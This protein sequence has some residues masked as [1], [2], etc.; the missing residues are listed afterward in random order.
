M[1][2]Y[3][4]EGQD[5]L[6]S[7]VVAVDAQ[8]LTDFFAKIAGNGNKYIVVSTHSDFGICEQKEF[9]AWK[10]I[11]KWCGMCAEPSIGYSDFNIHARLNKEKCNIEDKYS[12]KCWAWTS[13]TFNEIPSNVV[14]IFAT[15]CSVEDPRITNV[16]FGLAGIGDLETSLDKISTL[17]IDRPRDK[18]LY[19]NF[20]YCTIDRYRLFEFYHGMNWVTIY[21]GNRN[22]DEYYEDLATHKFV[23]CP[24]GNGLDCFRNLEALYCGAIPI[25]P[26]EKGLMFYLK[27][28]Q[29]ILMFKTLLNITEQFLN[30]F[31][32]KMIQ[33]DKNENIINVPFLR[34]SHWKN[35]IENK[36]KML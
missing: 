35:M 17:D 36:R 1:C 13:N 7:G 32:H 9:P 27:G 19:L 15:N 4:Y 16:P 8:A 2:D 30:E 33:T 3:A 11:E 10:D 6:P 29:R 22:A 24:A 25:F 20:Q 23:L 18:L 26:I 5:Y 21:Q 34:K 31:Y 12:V 28:K 14:H